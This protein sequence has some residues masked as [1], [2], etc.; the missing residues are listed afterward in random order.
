M[1]GNKIP[2]SVPVVGVKEVLG[3]TLPYRRREF[4]DKLWDHSEDVYT[5][6][7]TFLKGCEHSKGGRCLGTRRI[8]NGVAK[9]YV[10]QSYSQVRSHI[11]NFGR[12]LLELGLKRQE[13]LGIY[14]I[15]CAKWVITSY[16]CYREAFIVTSLYDTLGPEAIEHIVNETDM[17]YVVSTTDRLRDL[18]KLKSRL[19]SIHTI[20]VMDSK[21]DE[22]A[23]NE[24]NRAG[25][26]VYAFEEV[27]A[28]GASREE[29]S[30]LPKAENVA[31]ICYTSGTTG[32]PKG[33]V[34]TQANCV[35]TVTGFRAIAL[36]GTFVLI[37]HTSTYVSYLPLSHALERAAL[38]YA[39]LN[40]CNIGFYQGDPKKL[41]DDFVELNPTVICAVPRIFNRIY[42]GIHS[43]IKTKSAVVQF[44]FNYA[45][46]AKRKNIHKTPHHWLWDRLVFSAV[47]KKLGTN[48]KCLLNGSAPISG[49]VMEFL[50][51]C[52]STDMYEGYGHTEDYCGGCMTTQDSISSGV[53]GPPHPASEIKLKD[54]PEMQY[55][56][57]DK[58]FPRGE[59][60][61]RGHST[62][63]E[64][65]KNPEKTKEAIDNNG[66]FHTG[67]I[68][69]MDS[70]GN[71]VIID[72][73]KD[74]FKLSQGEYI[75]PE[76]IE[77]V[78]QKHELIDQA[79]VYGDSKQAYLV[80]I[81][82]P[83]KPNFLKW[84]AKHFPSEENLYSSDSL[85]KE[86][87]A[88]VNQYGKENGLKGFE[89][90]KAVHLTPKEFTMQDD[91]L[92]PTFKLRR[93]NL[94]KFY[95]VEI[96][97]LC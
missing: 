46:E 44:L 57:T 75:A 29:N 90:V 92:T 18:I 55:F 21:L 63:K 35:A 49:E 37:D 94:K 96:D 66:W 77:G 41:M 22:E 6:W 2:Y 62:I 30:E 7:D 23:R 56:T 84:T 78:Y 71:F 53:A 86:F 67:D 9:E 15:N 76:K 33:A 61:I 3:E 81:I 47:K 68:G 12:G 82:V 54:V 48:I 27:E 40:G 32:V 50:K 89:L 70:Y 80:G 16:A 19:P 38:G 52:F 73:L 34:L 17:E 83:D 91:L 36:V 79:Y 13:C 1:S 31:T 59:I 64:Y 72:R 24:A 58:P 28:K 8:E 88:T 87:L 93:H 65:Y 74:I 20:I 97:G 60:C 10:W 43:E 14:G 85:K 4:S 39:I 25:V 42:D 26:T 95:Q 11:E 45:V 69:T 51:I 5:L